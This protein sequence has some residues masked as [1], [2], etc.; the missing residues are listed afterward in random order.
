MS[1]IITTLLL[2]T[3]CHVVAALEGVPGPRHVGEHAD[4]KRRHVAQ[5]T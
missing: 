2:A 3:I 4:R 5:M 1:T